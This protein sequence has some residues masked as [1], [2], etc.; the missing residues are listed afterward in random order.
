MFIFIVKLYQVTGYFPWIIKDTSWNLS[1]CLWF[2]STLELFIG[3]DTFYLDPHYNPQHL[4]L[5][6]ASLLIKHFF[7]FHFAG[8][9]LLVH[10]YPV[11]HS[12]LTLWTV[13]HHAPLSMEFSRGGCHAVLQGIFPIQGPNP[14]CI[15][16]WILY[17]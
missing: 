12:C 3:Y 9:V 14:S 10:A 1:S 7:S 11:F 13:A 6:S 15:G 2:R 16:R 8:W 17:H 4:I 5:F